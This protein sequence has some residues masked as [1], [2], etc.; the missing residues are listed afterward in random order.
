[1]SSRAIRRTTQAGVIAALAVAVSG[2]VVLDKAVAVSF[3]GEVHQVHAFGGTVADVLEK[4][5]IRIGPHDVVTPSLESEVEEGQEIVVRR[6]HRLVLE[7][8]GQERRAWTTARTV[9]AALEDLDVR[10]GPGTRLSHPRATPVEDG[11]VLT[12]RTR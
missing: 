7:I 1:M 8:D 5:G 3:G 6:S 9:G 11:L 4:Q 2:V 12:V 10:I